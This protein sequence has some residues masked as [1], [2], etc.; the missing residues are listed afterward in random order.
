[1]RILSTAAAAYE[2]D[3]HV[4]LT[5]LGE[6]SI[7]GTCCS[8]H[9]KRANTGDPTEPRARPLAHVLGVWTKA[10]ATCQTFRPFGR[11]SGEL[12]DG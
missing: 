6:I 8:G 3:T 11:S 7:R 2:S 4:L 10:L 12:P 9:I 5:A 1:M